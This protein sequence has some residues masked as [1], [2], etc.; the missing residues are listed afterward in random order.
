MEST[1]TLSRGEF[2]AHL[3]AKMEETL[4]RE[5]VSRDAVAC[6]NKLA[7]PSCG[8]RKGAI[9]RAADQG[10][11]PSLESNHLPDEPLNRP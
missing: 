4:A 7:T 11:R 1:P 2:I 10:S 8:G 3:R 5:E 9:G 6:W